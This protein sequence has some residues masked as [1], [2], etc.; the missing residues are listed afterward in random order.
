LLAL[1]RRDSSPQDRIDDHASLLSNPRLERA[2]MR[3][4][5]CAASARIHCALAA[6]STRHQRPLKLIVRPQPMLTS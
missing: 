6:P 4:R 3:G 2:V 5:L 1:L